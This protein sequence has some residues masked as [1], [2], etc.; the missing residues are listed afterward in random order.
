MDRQNDRIRQTY[1]RLTKGASESWQVYA[2]EDAQALAG[3]NRVSDNWEKDSFAMQAGQEWMNAALCGRLPTT[4]E[5]C[6]EQL[7]NMVDAQL[8]ALLD[9]LAND[10][11]RRAWLLQ[12]IQIAR[13]VDECEMDEA[14]IARFSQ[15]SLEEMKESFVGLT[16][17]W[18]EN[19]VIPI[20]QEQC[21]QQSQQEVL[22]EIQADNAGALATAVYMNDPGAR[23]MPEAVGAC[24]ELIETCHNEENENWM[25]K[26]AYGLL[27]VAMIVAFL[28]L[29]ALVSVVIAAAVT[30]VV[31][32]GT[33]VGL[34]A[35]IVADLAL[36]SSTLVGMAVVSLGSLCLAGL[37]EGMKK[38]INFFKD[39]T[40]ATHSTTP[41]HI[42]I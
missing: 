2:G 7:W 24:A 9:G 40:V 23:K 22:P 5:A 8:Q 29:A 21:K 14:E 4:P 3:E 32:E 18:A 15:H 34:G 25:D 19:K 30:T 17:E 35:A 13:K 6:R 37:V 11:E 38:L 1:E 26:A 42:H 27:I 31:V 12:T 16:M 20:L 39:E 28:T 41:V 10:T 36:A 33:V